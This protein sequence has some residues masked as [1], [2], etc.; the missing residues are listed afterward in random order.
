MNFVEVLQRKELGF[1]S[2]QLKPFAKQPLVKLLI[3]TR[4]AFAENI[5][6]DHRVLLGG[7]LFLLDSESRDHLILTIFLFRFLLFGIQA[8]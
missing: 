7:G 4:W 3:R 5:H 8:N 6:S 1:G 2:R